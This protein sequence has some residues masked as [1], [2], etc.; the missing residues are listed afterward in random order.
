[1]PVGSSGKPVGSTNNPLAQSATAPYPLLTEESGTPTIPIQKGRIF[2]TA[3][4]ITT[5]FFAADLEP[6]NSPTTFRIYVA[7]DS[8]GVV[9]V[10]RTSGGVTVAELLNSGTALTA[11]SAYMFDVLVNEDDTIN[12]QDSVGGQILYCMVLEVPG[13]IS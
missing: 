8:G 5:D 7:L 1:M 4:A 10:Q 3:V 6:T 2:N 9:S 12:L 13:V 11:N